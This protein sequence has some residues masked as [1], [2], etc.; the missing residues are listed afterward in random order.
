MSPAERVAAAFAQQTTDKVPVYIAGI[1]SRVA[2]ALLGQEAWTSEGTLRF[3]E[4]A[5]LWEGESAHEEFLERSRRDRATLAEALDLDLVRVT[6]WRCN[7]RPTAQVDDEAFRYG[8]PEGQWRVMRF[9]PS[10]ERYELTDRGARPEPTFDDIEVEVNRIEE[11]ILTDDPEPE[12]YPEELAAVAAFGDERAAQIAPF[13]VG[14]PLEAVWLRALEE[15]R[16]LVS[17]YLSASAQRAA[18]T[19]QILSERGAKYFLNRC[20]F[21][22]ERGPVYSRAIFKEQLVPILQRISLACLATDTHHCFASRGNLRPVA[23]ELFGESDLQ[24]CCDIDHTAQVDLGRIRKRFPYV[25][26]MG[27]ISSETLCTG[28]GKRVVKE[29]MTALKAAKKRGGI[30]VGVSSEIPPNT[31]VE[32]VEAMLE[33]LRE[34]R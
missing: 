15:R 21:A 4:A 16:D 20:D 34:H 14:I 12:D 11:S 29:T 22:D 1:S 18:R 26:L 28:D 5:A 27:G 19:V 24:C 6:R 17:R 25:T 30:V 32:N 33:T 13:S 7:E 2:S 31:P 10:T 3:Q 8:G 23:R 9:D